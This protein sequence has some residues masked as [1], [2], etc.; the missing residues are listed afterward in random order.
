MS[1]PSA[2][3]GGPKFR[4]V[5]GRG[6]GER[7]S[8]GASVSG[9]SPLPQEIKPNTMMAP[10]SMHMQNPQHQQ[11]MQSQPQMVIQGAP[12]SDYFIAIK[13]IIGRPWRWHA[14]PNEPAAAFPI[15]Y[16]ATNPDK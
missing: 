6:L 15:E 12:P 2:P 5:A 3:S 13:I 8:P 14:G 11:P 1:D 10:V 16:T 7:P 4:I 9:N